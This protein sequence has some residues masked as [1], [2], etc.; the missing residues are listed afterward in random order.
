MNSLP[1]VVMQLCPEKDLN[2]RFVDCKSNTLP[3]APLQVLIETI[4]AMLP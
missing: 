4:Y 1:K 2:P 3:I